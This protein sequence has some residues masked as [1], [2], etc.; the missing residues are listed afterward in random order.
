MT[1]PASK[2][3]AGALSTPSGDLDPV[4]PAERIPI[5]DV[6]RGF[7]LFGVLWSN[8]NESV[9]APDWYDIIQ[10]TLSPSVPLT[11][12]DRGLA[13][14]QAWLIHGRFYTLLGLLF[15]IGFAIQLGRAETRGGDVRRMFYRR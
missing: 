15:G 12:L 11:G 2:V 3:A 7:C 1:S 6:L 8:L 14:A 9:G 4:A 13:W 5:L 10:G